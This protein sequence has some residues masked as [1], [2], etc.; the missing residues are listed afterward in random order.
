M[1]L[2]G[3]DA[4]IVCGY[5]TK[6][7]TYT[8]YYRDVNDDIAANT[9]IEHIRFE[10]GTGTTTNGTGADGTQTV[11][12][13]TDSDLSAVN[14]GGDTATVVNGDG[15]DSNT[16]RIDD[17]ETPLASGQ[18]GLPVAA[19]VGIGVGVAALV[20]LIVFLVLK[21]KK[22]DDAAPAADGQ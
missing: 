6:Y 8:V 7:D 4:P 19:I 5:Y 11:S 16:A 20:L 14:N 2:A 15:V 21:R 22:N 18:S 3:Q 13:P 10:Y 12:L 17:N 9:K 1:R